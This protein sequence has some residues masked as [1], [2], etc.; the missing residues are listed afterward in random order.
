MRRSHQFRSPFASSIPPNGFRQDFRRCFRPILLTL[1]LGLLACGG[2]Q[3]PVE[4]L[5]TIPFP[6]LSAAETEVRR[7]LGAAQEAWLAMQAD[8]EV[9]AADR[10]LSVGSLGELYQAYDLT[11]AAAASYRNARR[12]APDEPRWPYLLGVLHRFEG[13]G[14]AARDELHEALQLQP[15]TATRL[16]LAWVFLD[17]G[18]LDAAQEQVEAAMELGT[19]FG[20]ARALEG[21]I[22]LEREDHQGAV[23]AFEAALAA[24]PEAN[25]LH[26]FLGRAYRKLGDLDAAKR[27]LEQHGT[28]DAAFADPRLA[29]IY[30][31]LAGSA[32]LMQ[33][34][35]SAKQSGALEA[36]VGIY[37]Q[38]VM[39]DPESPEARR[40][41]GA[42]LAQIG[43]YEEAAEQ[44]QE[45]VRLEP[46][47]GLNHFVLALVREQLGKSE[48]VLD[49]L[50][51][52]VD[53]EPDYREFR[54]A[55]ASR[56]ARGGDLPAAQQQFQAL[57]SN[58]PDDLDVR[59]EQAKLELALGNVEAALADAEKV[60]QESLLPKQKAEALTVKADGLIR[61]NQP[62]AAR[63]GLLQAL[64]LDPANVGA[65][66]S[67]GNLSG[68]G[69][70]FETAL[71]HYRTV[72]E[73]DPE[74]VAAWLGEATALVLLERES[75]AVARLEAGIQQLPKYPAL[76]F[77]FARLLLVP[78]DESLRDPQRALQ[79]ARQLWA[80][81]QQPQHADLLIEALAA[82][83]SY[84]EAIDMQDKMLRSAP[85]RVAPGIIE[86]WQDRLN[87]LRQQQASR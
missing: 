17:L 38:A 33:R 54:F 31:R 57:L 13:E 77:S 40:D 41:L 49:G 59:L 85:G 45:A 30:A 70:D 5:E 32:A 61:Q 47:K 83:G 28:R 10:A 80:E 86:V 11:E 63:Q 26:Y 24:Q 75:E 84:D 42:L 15:D 8:P 18:Q 81:Q 79:M 76:R 65:H 6:D 73:A 1:V 74:R 66:F 69:G 20:A 72:T 25:R 58:D 55:Y 36:S 53:L 50:R 68:M 48:A 43:R 62:E 12:L 82:T 52:A 71:R 14:E 27:H 64:E 87:R 37:R 19:D 16:H 3:L 46:E 22:A 39:G 56:L 34:G 23:A 44:Y 21:R 67:L 29:S 78:R 60:E 2:P 7:Q 4:P 35:A 9:E 51:Q